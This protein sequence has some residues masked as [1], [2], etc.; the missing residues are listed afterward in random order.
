MKYFALLLVLS[1]SFHIVSAQN[2]P[3]STKFIRA[4]FHDKDI[5][6]TDSL[7]GATLKEIKK[8]IDSSSESNYFFLGKNKKNHEKLSFTREE[9]LYINKQLSTLQFFTWQPGLLTDAK[10][11]RI[12]TIRKI[13]ADSGQFSGWQYIYKHYGRQICSFSKPIFLRHTTV[14]IFY[15]DYDC[16]SLCG[17]GGLSVYI[18]RNGIWQ[19]AFMLYVWMS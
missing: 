6:Y 7:G 4:I 19:R 13:F 12:D 18:K 8:A 2:D 1:L 15:S 16:G 9:K 3:A 14:C 11:V 17:G 10:F 5:V